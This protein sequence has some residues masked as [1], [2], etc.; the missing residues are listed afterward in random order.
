VEMS[1]AH[2]HGAQTVAMLAARCLL[3]PSS[4]TT[5]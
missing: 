5:L 3:S 4:I 1:S 2:K